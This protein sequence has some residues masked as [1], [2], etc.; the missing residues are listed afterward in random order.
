MGRLGG[1]EFA[2]LMPGVSPAEAVS[3]ATRLRAALQ[4]PFPV[5]GRDLALDASLGI[6]VSGPDAADTETLF[7][8]ADIAM[9]R[10]KTG[11]TGV[12]LFES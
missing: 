1:D 5:E 12:A 11:R 3:A 7:R 9:Y 8:Q 2:V 4:V 6:A 10:A